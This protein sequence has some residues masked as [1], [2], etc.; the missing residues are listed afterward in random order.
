MFQNVLK[1]NS[2]KYMY[3]LHRDVCLFRKEEIQLKLFFIINFH[4]ISLI[5]N[6]LNY[7]EIL[8]FFTTERKR[9]LTIL[10]L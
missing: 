4:T 9:C 2:Y 3:A 10:M 8:L 6:L 1:T 5:G 7:A